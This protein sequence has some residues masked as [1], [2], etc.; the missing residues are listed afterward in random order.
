M[1]IN[2]IEY[3]TRGGREV[4]LSVDTDT[5]KLAGFLRLSLPTDEATAL[6]GIDEL[7]GAAIIREVH[8]YGPV[9]ELGRSGR[10]Q[11]AAFRP[12]RDVAAR[13]GGSRAGGRVRSV[14]GDQRDRHAALLLEARL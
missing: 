14:S 12:R 9:V 2:S 5:G 13:G 3:E 4:F 1:P 11:G 10:R 8:V 7:R 6:T